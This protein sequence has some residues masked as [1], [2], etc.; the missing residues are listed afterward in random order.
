MHPFYWSKLEVRAG[1]SGS[2]AGLH[3]PVAPRWQRHFREVVRDRSCTTQHMGYYSEIDDRVQL[4]IRVRQLEMKSTPVQGQIVD[5]GLLEQ[6]G[7]QSSS[8][9][10]ASL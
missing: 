9:H 4:Q 8:T 6:T 10:K 7:L 5:S 3:S 2:S 1:C